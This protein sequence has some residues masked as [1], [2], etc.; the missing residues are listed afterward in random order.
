[1]SWFLGHFCEQLM[2]PFRHNYLV[3][4]AQIH[5]GGLFQIRGLNLVH[6]LK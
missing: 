1:M 6:A 2:Q 5:K 3:T 4:K